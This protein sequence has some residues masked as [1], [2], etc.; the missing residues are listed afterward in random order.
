MGS[1]LPHLC[2]DCMGSPLPHLR[3]HWSSPFRVRIGT[4][5]AWARLT[6]E[7]AHSPLSRAGSAEPSQ[8]RAAKRMRVARLG[9]AGARS[10]GQVQAEKITHTFMVPTQVRPRSVSDRPRHVSTYTY[11]YIYTYMYIY[12]YVYIYI[13]VHIGLARV[14]AHAR[15][16]IRAPSRSRL[17][18]ALGCRTHARAR[19]G[20]SLPMG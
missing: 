8:R 13:H 14:G 11:V 19:A 5:T 4:A 6:A 1:P 9:W 15:M 10:D 20:G 3:P 12:T 7:A 17:L 18:A 16:R 2:R